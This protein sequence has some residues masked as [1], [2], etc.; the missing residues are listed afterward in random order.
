[1]IAAAAAYQEE[2]VTMKDHVRDR[3]LSATAT[4]RVCVEASAGLSIFRDA[5]P[6][7]PASEATILA[8]SDAGASAECAAGD[9]AALRA[10]IAFL[11]VLGERVCG[12]VGIEA[13]GITGRPH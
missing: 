10:R 8:A 3:L 11:A 6:K 2:I 12:G 13:S 4:I 1:M 5:P 9:L 7:E